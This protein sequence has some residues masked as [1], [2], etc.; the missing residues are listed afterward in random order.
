[1]LVP[2]DIQDETHRVHMTPCYKK[3]TLI[4]TGELSREQ[5]NLR[6]SK[7]SSDGNSTWVYPE[8]CRFCVKVRVI[9]REE[10]ASWKTGYERSTVIDETM[11]PWKRL[12]TFLRNTTFKLNCKKLLVSWALQKRFYKI[13]KSSNPVSCIFLPK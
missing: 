6:L 4:L 1:M 11:S 5:S 12:R 9:Y 3:F 10:S 8:V 7:R 13:K 2:D